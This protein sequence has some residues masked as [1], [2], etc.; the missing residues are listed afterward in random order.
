MRLFISHASEDKINFVEPLVASLE[1]IYEVWFDKRELTLGDSL[2]QKINEGLSNADFGV[3]VLSP[4]Y[5]KKWPLAELDGLFALETTTRKVILPIWKDISAEEVRKSYPVLAGRFALHAS[6][7]VENIVAAIRAAVESSERTRELTILGSARDH[8][9]ELDETLTERQE[10]NR[11]LQSPEGAGLVK[12][13]ADEIFAGVTSTLSEVAASSGVLKFAFHHTP[14][15]TF[16]IQGNF[17]INLHLHVHRLASNSAIGAQFIL[18]TFQETGPF[19]P[20]FENL[21]EHR[22]TPSFRRTRQV[23]WKTDKGAQ[24][25]SNDELS[26]HAIDVFREQI[27]KAGISQ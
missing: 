18:S 26:S 20:D 1:K 7:G 25:F 16:R 14:P 4:N 17:G 12:A 8:V 15:V 21:T 6:E 9:R 22:L 3:V 10:S 23:V 2:L 13:A 24:A 5:A 27:E 11:L 19:A